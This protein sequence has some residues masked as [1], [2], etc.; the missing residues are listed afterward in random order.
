MAKS[1]DVTPENYISLDIIKKKPTKLSD[2]EI[3]ALMDDNPFGINVSKNLNNNRSKE[4]KFTKEE[5]LISNINFEEKIKTK[6]EAK[7]KKK[8]A[9]KEKE[10][11]KKLKQRKKSSSLKTIKEIESSRDETKRKFILNNSELSPNQL[12]DSLRKFKELHADDI[13]YLIC[14]LEKTNMGKIKDVWI[15]KNEFL[16]YG[17]QTGNLTDSKERCSKFVRI[18]EGRKPGSKSKA[19]PFF[20]LK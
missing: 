11:E 16:K 1:F 19:V 14:V 6:L 3:E 17:M 5:L 4:Q 13:K 8:L 2:K 15:P 18:R 20:S 9:E 7:Y 12:Y 10:L